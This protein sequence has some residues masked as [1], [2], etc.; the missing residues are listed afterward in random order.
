MFRLIEFSNAA[1]CN[2]FVYDL[3]ISTESED[4]LLVKF[5]LSILLE[6]TM[7]LHPNQRRLWAF[8]GQFNKKNLS[9]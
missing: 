3:F 9:F 8:V 1:K 7:R 5:V 4:D 6:V 2:S